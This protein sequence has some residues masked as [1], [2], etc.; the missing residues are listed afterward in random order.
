MLMRR[1][2]WVVLCFPL[3]ANAQQQAQKSTLTSATI[4]DIVSY[5]LKNQPVIQQ[6]EIDE[7]ITEKAIKGR[8]ADWYP[9]LNFTY[10]Y[11]RFIDLQSSVIGGNLIRFGVDNTSSAQ[12]TASQNVFNRDVLLASKTAST[13]RLQAHQNTRLQKIEI[14]ANVKKATYDV[15]ATQQ[16]IKVSEESILRL[17]QSLKD[18]KSRY[19][20]GV[21]DK[22]DYQRASILLRNAQATLT[23][24]KA[25]LDHKMSFL[26]TLMGYP[27][28][29][30]LNIS[31]DEQRLESSIA[32]DTTQRVVFDSHINYEL[33]QTKRE[34]QEANLTHSK[35][36]FL[37]SVNIFGAY[38]LNYQNNNFSELYDQKFPYSYVGATVSLPLFQGGK[39]TAKVQEARLAYN[40]IGTEIT[41]LKNQLNTGYAQ[42]LAGYKTNLAMYLAQK[43]NTELAQEV[44]DIIRLQY[45]NGVRTYLDVT[46]AES[47]LRTT[48]INYFNALYRVLASRVEVEKSL[49][50]INY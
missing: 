27:E 34:L 24:H 11:Q 10:N 23:A 12:F 30:E 21:S 42:A 50:L 18:A 16:Q 45:T 22:T 3:L 41:N 46:T 4:D 28:D 1:V 31:Y 6:A 7:Q 36:A 26:K 17:S 13:V 8:L 49:G 5:A 39:R 38:N 9:Q 43:E 33:L 40:R 19:E 14:V 2:R 29:E 35:W 37:P 48:R 25:A 47:E 20:A 32:I 44:Y 15:L